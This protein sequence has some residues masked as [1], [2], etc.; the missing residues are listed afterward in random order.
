MI[1]RER[2]ILLSAACSFYAANPH[3]TKK[4]FKVLQY[5]DLKN[6][7]YYTP[8]DYTSKQDLIEKIAMYYNVRIFVIIDDECYET[9]NSGNQIYVRIDGQNSVRFH[10]NLGLLVKLPSGLG[11]YSGP[12]HKFDEMIKNRGFD[13]KI[14]MKDFSFKSDLNRIE[15]ET[16]IGINIWQKCRKTFS[17]CDI[18]QIRK[19]NVR[20]KKQLNL[21]LEQK[22]QHLFLIL[23]KALYFRGFIR[24]LKIN[25]Q[26]E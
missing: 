15:R 5:E 26:V 3:M 11:K 2:V 21:H 23:N 1:E 22:T 8:T 6:E 14:K 10:T 12:V 24:K 17:K 4:Q 13:A 18:K 16:S 7:K 19:S 9:K 25:H 20:F